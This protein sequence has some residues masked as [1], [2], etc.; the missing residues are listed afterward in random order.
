V[1]TTDS[2]HLHQL[3][4]H[5]ADG[6]RAF[7]FHFVDRYEQPVPALLRRAGMAEP[8]VDPLVHEVALLVMDL[9]AEIR[10]ITNPWLLVEQAVRQVVADPDL[11]T[12]KLRPLDRRPDATFA[13]RALHLVDIENLAGGPARVDVWFTPAVHEYLAVAEPND[14]DQMITAADISLWRRTAFDIPLGR[15]LP[16]RGPDGADHA[17]LDAAPAEWVSSRFHRLVIG[18][19]DHAFTDLALAVRSAGVEVVV[20]ARPALLSGSLRRSADVVVALP[21]LPDFPHPP[22][23]ADLTLAA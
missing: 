21:N 4:R 7:L 8:L 11:A 6:D 14:A 10:A 13:G 5:V 16:G 19:G 2:T 20:V 18:S 9:A 23:K 22:A 15:Y 1:N 17:L 12:A 3:L